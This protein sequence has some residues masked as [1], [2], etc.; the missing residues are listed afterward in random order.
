MPRLRRSASAGCGL[1]QV[2]QNQGGVL[3]SERYA[4]ADRMFDL[5]GPARF[6]Y[7]VQIA[8]RIRLLQ[9]DGGRYL[10]MMHGDKRSRDAGRAACAL[11]MSYLRLQARHRSAIGC[12]AQ[13]E[14]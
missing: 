10:A 9:I 14:L 6:G 5:C 12:V 4:V 2:F 13:G 11:R 1:S 8:L 3:R 7:V